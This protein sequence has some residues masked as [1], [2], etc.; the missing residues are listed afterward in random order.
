MGV[1]EITFE[2]YTIYATTML[3][4][5]KF[6]HLNDVLFNSAL[7]SADLDMRYTT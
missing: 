2:C 4:F 6:N 1:I 5:K 3:F 7:P